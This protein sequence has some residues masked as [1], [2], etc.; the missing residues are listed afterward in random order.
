MATE[1][2]EV[3]GHIIDS[4]IL[5]KVLDTIVDT[6]AEYRIVDF[7]I[8]KA[9]TDPSRARIQV[10]AD[11]DILTTLLAQLQLHG[12]NRVE[13]A[14]ATLEPSDRDGV[15]PEG[16]YSTTNLKTQVRLGGHWVDVENPEM[17]CA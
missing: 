11:E 3:E 16:F 4:L 14:D 9:S 7:E 6:G 1:V 8:G 5:A 17:D 10:D 13:D 15:L 12:A 2:V